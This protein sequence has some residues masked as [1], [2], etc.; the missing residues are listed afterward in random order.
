[1]DILEEITERTKERICE[2]KRLYPLFEVRER[3]ERR[4]TKEAFLFERALKQPD[5]SFLCEIKKASPS[6]GIIDETFPYKKIA[7]EYEE[8]GAE[9]ISCLTEP[10]YFQGKDEYLETIANEVKIPILRKDFVIEEYM[11]YEAKAIGASAILL[12]CSILDDA[13]LTEYQQL[14][15]ELGLSALVEVHSKAEV[16]RA[17]KANAS[18]IG[19][20]NRNLR[21]FQVDFNHTF[22]IR[23]EVPKDVLFVSESGITT[24][25]QIQVLREYQVDGVLIGE[26]L[27]RAENKKAE[28]EKLRNG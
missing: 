13:Q 27:M 1:M 21:T 7:K 17:L 26:T 12:I 8:A 25:K 6:K 9:A 16:M 11:I 20:N 10:Y 22:A 4:K 5:I 18:M 24:P 2:K 23:A 28:L 15:S 14:A 19:V 3:A